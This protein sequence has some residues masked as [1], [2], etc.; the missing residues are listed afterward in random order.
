V[1]ALDPCTTVWACVRDPVLTRACTCVSRLQAL[2]LDVDGT[3]TG[4]QAPVSVISDYASLAFPAPFCYP[5]N[6][7]GG[8][9]CPKT[10]L[11]NTMLL[12][13]TVRLVCSG[14]QCSGAPL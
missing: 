14:V 5:M 8:Y 6:Q 7:W 11:R 4:Y 3:F 2:L 13:K 10:T 12:N 9:V 1:F